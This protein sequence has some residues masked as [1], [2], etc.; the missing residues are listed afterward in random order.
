MRVG[1]STSFSVSATN[2]DSSKSYSIQVSTSN[3][4]LG[5]DG[6]C[7]DQQ[8]EATVPADDTSHTSTLTLRACSTGGGIVTATLLQDGASVD[9]DT[10]S[11]TVTTRPRPPTPPTPTISIS[12]LVN[13]MD[14]G[15]NDSFTVTASNLVSSASY[16]IELTT[17]DAAIGFNSDCTDREE[18]LTVTA[19][20]L[21]HTTGPITLYGCDAERGK[22]TAT[23]KSGG[24]SLVSAEQ[25][26]TVSPVIVSSD[27][28][29]QISG[30]LGTVYVGAND[31]F[32]VSA[33]HLDSLESYTIRVSTNNAN[34]GFD[35]A[36]SDQ[37]ED[38]TVTAGV[39]SYT[40]NTLTLYGCATTDGT[41]TA[42][43]SRDGSTVDTDTHSLTV[44]TPPPPPTPPTPTIRISELVSPMDRGDNAPFTV[45]ASNLDS[46]ASYTIEVSTDDTG[47]GFDSNCTD[48]ARDS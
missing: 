3:T 34:I 21:S 29:V 9:T 18:P 45:T 7:T 33:S 14:M 42:T 12:G 11:L 24:G 26:V 46:S 27:P 20:S 13:T 43:L 6:G 16:T 28:T 17:D 47:I 36:C 8:D 48:Q 37:Q 2:L 22:V 44:T 39:T 32:T 35:S 15:D 25:T 23:L 38:A 5:F 1:T 19:N 40:T 10:H 4:N 41:V 31:A 30:L